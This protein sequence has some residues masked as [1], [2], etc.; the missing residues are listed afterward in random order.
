MRKFLLLFIA[1]LIVFLSVGATAKA[2]CGRHAKRFGHRR[3]ASTH[4]STANVTYT[5]NGVAPTVAAPKATASPAP[6]ATPTCTSGS[7]GSAEAGR[8]FFRRR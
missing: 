5:C 7:C 4:C 6:V 8:I 2:G 1:T 3:E